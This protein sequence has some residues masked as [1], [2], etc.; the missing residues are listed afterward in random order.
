MR[1]WELSISSK[2]NSDFM[3]QAIRLATEN[4]LHGAGGPFGCVIVRDG[5]VIATGTNRVTADNDPTAHAEIL[6][7]REACS[8]LGSF[9]LTG[10]EV[11]TS[12]EPCPMCLAALYW[13]RCE[14]IYYGNTASDAAAVGFDDH[15]LYDELKLS[16]DE[17]TI[18]TQRML[19][20]EAIASFE[21]WRK[22]PNRIDY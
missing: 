4:V 3:L 7:I 19:G 14:A 6:A 15:F 13:A 18:P 20:D 1:H 22:N 11:Y 12:C 17:R 16:V 8:K 2:G 9:Q 21:A 5:K 10:C